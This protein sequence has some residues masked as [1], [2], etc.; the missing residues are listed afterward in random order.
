M[1]SVWIQRRP[2]IPWHNDLV[3]IKQVFKDRCQSVKQGSINF[4]LKLAI[5]LF[6]NFLFGQIDLNFLNN[7]FLNLDDDKVVKCLSLLERLFEL[8]DNRDLSHV[9]SDQLKDL[10]DVFVHY[11]I[12]VGLA[13]E[14]HVFFEHV[15]GQLATGYN[16]RDII[17]GHNCLSFLSTEASFI[18]ETLVKTLG[19]SE[20]VVFF[21]LATNTVFSA[22][23]SFG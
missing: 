17:E 16:H 5:V 23:S 19:W 21:V 2:E 7:V 18:L 22:S 3:N 13:V 10:L 14:F 4:R 9:L 6:L 1:L 8:Y 11:L 20:V 15:E 12:V